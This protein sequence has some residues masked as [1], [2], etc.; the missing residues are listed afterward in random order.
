M[1]KEIEMFSPQKN[2]D[3][4]NYDE[5]RAFVK[6]F[7]NLFER[8][9]REYIDTLENLDET[10]FSG[11]FLKEQNGMKAKIVATAEKIE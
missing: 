11:H 1:S 10:N 7:Y 8:F 9:K 2:I 5:L 6:K 4:M 3:D